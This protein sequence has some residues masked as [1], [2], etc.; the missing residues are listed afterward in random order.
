[1][2]SLNEF[3][4]NYQIKIAAGERHFVGITVPVRYVQC[5]A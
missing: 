1:M 2:H 3:T 4:H 5:A